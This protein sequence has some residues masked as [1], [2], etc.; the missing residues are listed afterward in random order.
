MRAHHERQRVAAAAA[1]QIE[2]G[3]EKD[4]K[5]KR[6]ARQN[7]KLCPAPSADV[8]RTSAVHPDKWGCHADKCGHAGRPPRDGRLKLVALKE[9]RFLSQPLDFGGEFS[10]APEV[11]A[12]LRSSVFRIVC[13]SR[14]L[15][16]PGLNGRAT[17]LWMTVQRTIN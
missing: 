5:R 6:L 11:E 1:K 9:S 13:G 4:R 15:I 16:A 14:L 2:A 12:L 8:Q 7:A 17:H 3:R 10:I